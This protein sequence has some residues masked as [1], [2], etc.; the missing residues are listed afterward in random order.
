MRSPRRYILENE[1][2]PLHTIPA[3]FN[4]SIELNSSARTV[5]RYIRKL[6]PDCYTAVRKIYLS[7]KN[8]E[9]RILWPRTHVVWTHTRSSKVLFTGKSSFTVRLVEIDC[10]YGK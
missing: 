7:S 10:V 6:K 5:R 3:Q 4:D 9:A 2:E 1:F 8:I